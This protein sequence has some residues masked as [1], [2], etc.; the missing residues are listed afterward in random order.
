VATVGGCGG[1]DVDVDGV[2]QPRLGGNVDAQV[3]AELGLPST[4]GP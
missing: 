1:V 3:L 4:Y 2:A